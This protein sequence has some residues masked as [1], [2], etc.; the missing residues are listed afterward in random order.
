MAFKVVIP[1][2]LN[3]TRLPGKVLLP[4]LDK[5]LI[6]HVWDRASESGAEQVVV[7]TDSTQVR[8]VAEGFGAQVCMTASSHE[9]GTDRIHEA[10]SQ[11]GWGN[12]S[13][14][15][16]LQGDEPAMPPELVRQVAHNLA[17]NAQADMA[18]LCHAIESWTDWQ[19]PGQVKVVRDARDMALYFSRSPIPY[20]RERA[21]HASEQ[22]PT[23]GAWA[24]IGL[25]AYRVEALHRFSELPVAPL[26]S[27]EALEQLRALTHGLRIHVAEA[28]CRPGTGVDTETDMPRAEAELR[29]L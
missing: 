12:D 15:V 6:Q 23:C 14:V 3:S 29:R 11:L 1:A 19:D 5:P 4:L 25:Y 2:R 10:V 8:D 24:H 26:E 17:E 9:S 21:G 22:L 28:A 13:I 7:A 27:T 16:N 18:T 20:D